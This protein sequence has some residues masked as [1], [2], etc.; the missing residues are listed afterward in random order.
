MAFVEFV[1]HES[2][3]KALVTEVFTTTG[4]QLIAEER[5]KTNNRS[6]SGRFDRNN[7]GYQSGR[8]NDRNGSS[9]DRQRPKGNFNNRANKND[10]TAN[11]NN[12]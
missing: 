9:N 8:Q 7:N 12:A 3:S 11:T 4:V 6:N 2:V 1:N 10:K 5:K